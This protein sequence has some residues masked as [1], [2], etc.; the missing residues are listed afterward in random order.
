VQFVDGDVSISQVQILSHQY[1][2]SLRT[3]TTLAS[4]SITEPVCIKTDVKK[5]VESDPVWNDQNLVGTDNPLR[6]RSLARRLSCRRSN[7]DS[8]LTVQQN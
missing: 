7:S 5:T 2:F 1:R 4:L 3:L 8:A 6:G